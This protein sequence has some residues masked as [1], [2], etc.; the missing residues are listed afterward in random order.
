MIDSYKIHYGDSKDQCNIDL[1]NG[2]S[3]WI[4]WIPETIAE[5]DSLECMDCRKALKGCAFC[6]RSHDNCAFR[7]TL[8]KT[9]QKQSSIMRYI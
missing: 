1:V 5:C 6:G 4:R 9:I 3:S 7:D 8:P 2:N